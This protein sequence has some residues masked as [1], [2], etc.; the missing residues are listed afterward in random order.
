MYFRL[1]NFQDGSQI[2]NLSNIFTQVK[3]L[4]Y[5]FGWLYYISAAT[6]FTDMN[7]LIS[8]QRDL[9]LFLYPTFS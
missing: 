4:Y 1:R 5:E 2:D 9:L 6:S 3:Y 8:L 7:K